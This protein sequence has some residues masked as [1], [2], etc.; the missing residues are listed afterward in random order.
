MEKLNINWMHVHSAIKQSKKVTIRMADGRSRIE[1]EFPT[2]E[3]TEAFC[4]RIIAE[5]K[6]QRI[7]LHVEGYGDLVYAG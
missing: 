1:Y 5:A 2:L 4:E 6:L 7:A 3:E